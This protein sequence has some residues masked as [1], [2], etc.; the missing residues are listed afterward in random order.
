[1]YDDS[2]KFRPLFD[3][4]LYENPRYT[5]RGSALY[6]EYGLFRALTI[7]GSLPLKLVEQDADGLPGTVDIHGETFGFGDLHLGARV[8]LVRGRWAAAIE[9]DLK[10]PLR[11]AA[12]AGSPD[13]ALS[14]GFADFGASLCLGA[15]LPRIRGYG[16]GS[17]GY[18]IRSGRIADE[19]YWDVEVGSEPVRGLRVRFRYDGVR[20]ERRPVGMVD[21]GTNAPVPSAGEQDFHRIAPTLAVGVGGFHE[22]SFT[23]RRVVDGRSTIR[24]SEWEVGFSFL[25]S[26]VPV[27]QR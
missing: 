26:V 22:L 7:L 21:A 15:S 11:G 3:P 25:G 6:V 18:R 16:Q 20:S 8:P 19:A 4:G 27:P 1:M 2:G 23:W 10:I 24:S 9:P 12:R 17:G 14:T 13:P 5:E